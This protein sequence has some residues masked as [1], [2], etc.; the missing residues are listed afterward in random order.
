MYFCYS[1]LEVN[2]TLY[3]T[4]DLKLKI[5]SGHSS[6]SDFQLKMNSKPSSNSDF[7]KLKINSVTSN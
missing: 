2:V 3:N 1:K 5:H 4:S 7:F 6:S